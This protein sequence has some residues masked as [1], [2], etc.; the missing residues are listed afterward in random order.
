MTQVHGSAAN[1]TVQRP[2]G[3]AP[4]PSK[5]GSRGVQRP[6]PS[7]APIVVTRPRWY[8]A[9]KAA[10]YLTPAERTTLLT[11]IRVPF[12]DAGFLE[13]L[14]GLHGSAAVYRRLARLR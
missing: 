10:A 8:D 5:A 14:E 7:R 3:R 12:A 13:Q 4:V 1:H 2:S 6:R 9:E 11:L